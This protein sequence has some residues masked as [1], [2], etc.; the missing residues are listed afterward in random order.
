[1]LAAI[2][3]TS[4]DSG[5]LEVTEV[6]RPKPG[7]DEVRVR[8]AISGVNPTDWKAL[9]AAEPP[10]WGFAV[11]NQDG[12]GVID[13]VGAGVPAERVGERVWLLLAAR[14][15]QW[16]T[17]AQYSIVPAQR[18]VPLPTGASFELGASL[19]VPALTA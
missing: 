6:D 4:G 13:A 14:D 16:G 1:M 17:A 15:R 19:G 9:R 5:A 3:R 18:A 8:V 2:Y 12:A 11:P 10:P 7:P